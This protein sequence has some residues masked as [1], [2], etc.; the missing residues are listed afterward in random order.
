[1]P[2]NVRKFG[3]SSYTTKCCIANKTNTWTDMN[4]LSAEVLFLDIIV[5]STERVHCF[6]HTNDLLTHSACLHNC[7]K[8]DSASIQEY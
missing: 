5:L 2:P 1:M 8:Y 4:T 7:F 6:E 3:G